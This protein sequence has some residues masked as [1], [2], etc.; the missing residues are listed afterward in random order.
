MLQ[1]QLDVADI[2]PIILHMGCDG[3]AEQMAGTF[4]TCSYFSLKAACEL[5]ARIARCE[6]SSEVLVAESF[7]CPEILP[8][9][10]IWLIVDREIY[11]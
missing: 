4:L 2:G 9:S 1:H 8:S 10:G 3:M 6:M 11:Q 7:G 5:P